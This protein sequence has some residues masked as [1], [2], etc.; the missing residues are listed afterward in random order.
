MGGNTTR[1]KYRTKFAY[2][3]RKRKPVQPAKRRRLSAPH[4]HESRDSS[5][6]EQAAISPRD[7]PQTALASDDERANLGQSTSH[8]AAGDYQ[9][10]SAVE[11]LISPEATVHQRSPARSP[12]RYRRQQG[13]RS[14]R[15]HRPE[16]GARSEKSAE[17]RFPETRCSVPLPNSDLSDS[18]VRDAAL[19]LPST[20]SGIAA[21]QQ[22]QFRSGSAAYLKMA[23]SVFV[24][25]WATFEFAQTFLNFLALCKATVHEDVCEE[26]GSRSR[27]SKKLL[28]KI[29]VKCPP[30]K[31]A[32][33]RSSSGKGGGAGKTAPEQR[34]G[35]ADADS[36]GRPASR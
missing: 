27:P 34:A 2:G 11:R 23:R 16:Q 1:R 15:R 24:T 14:P 36:P 5:A 21:P 18:E 28:E 3:K 30:P 12:R 20:S 32:K 8:G 6:E 13:S 17:A 31:E 25:K 33:R 35:S 4:V 10:D 29:D 26:R 9:H 19:S 22:P 7:L